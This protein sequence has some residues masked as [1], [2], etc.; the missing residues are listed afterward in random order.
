MPHL[1]EGVGNE[2]HA[3]RSSGERQERVYALRELR[4]FYGSKQERFGERENWGARR[5]EWERRR[6]DLGARLPV[7]GECLRYEEW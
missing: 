6:S 4:G 3:L 2:L 7:L 1:S 5:G